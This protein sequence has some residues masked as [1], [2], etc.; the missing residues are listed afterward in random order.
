M[1]KPWGTGERA[2]EAAFAAS[3]TPA[4]TAPPSPTV[5]P[6]LGYEGRAYDP[7]IFGVHEPE[8]TWA[9]WPAGFLVTFGFVIQVPGFVAAASPVP[10]VSPGASQQTV[11]AAPSPAADEPVWPSRF[12]VPDGNHLLLIGINMPRGHSLSTASLTRLSADGG[13]GLVQIRLFPSPWPSHFAV[14]GIPAADDSTH[15]SVWPAG[16]YRLDMS[17]E[18]DGV[19]RSIEIV[20]VTPNLP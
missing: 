19:A 16:H 10:A 17:F 13:A 11:S 2:P 20:I 4:I 14:I 8:A 18:P 12:D 1:L 9:I 15:L 6:V 7:S 3:P 5:A